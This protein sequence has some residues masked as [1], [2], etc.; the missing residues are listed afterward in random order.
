MAS[1]T[2]RP[3]PE[4]LPRPKAHTPLARARLLRP[5]ASCSCRLSGSLMLPPFLPGLTTWPIGRAG[6]LRFPGCSPISSATCT[7]W[8]TLISSS[9]TRPTKE[10]ARRMLRRSGVEVDAADASITFHRIPT[11]R[12]W[13]RDTGPIFVREIAN[14]GVQ[15]FRRSG[16]L[17]GADFKRVADVKVLGANSRS[18]TPQTLSLRTQNS[19]LLLALDWRFNAWAKYPD[20][21]RDDTV[22]S[23]LA[24]TL[25][26]ATLPPTYEPESVEQ[27][28]TLADTKPRSRSA[29]SPEP[30]RVVLEGAA[31]TSTARASC[32][33]TEEC[34]LDP[35]VQMRNPGF[36]RADYERVFR[37]YLGIEKTIWLRNGVAG[38]DTHGHVDDLARFVARD[39][40]VIVS[41][42]DPRDANHEPL[43][44]NLA[45]LGRPA[46]CA[47]SLCASSLSPCPRPSSLKASVF[48]QATPISTSPTRLSS[49]R[50]S[51][52]P[53]IGSP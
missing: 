26:Y 33:T 18:P 1:P 48:R 9:M 28:P 49:F 45:M 14:E 43:K 23:R 27:T 50:P 20:W 42:P 25:G 7:A 2:R 12:I 19:S 52:I 44:E 6:L 22:P 17:Q 29:R 31:L 24:A 15:A 41:E 10:R 53:T 32:S 34:L 30:R 4:Q 5:S 35:V 39:T 51:T 11:N 47:A 36:S 16:V 37:D 21:E 40:I 38:D 46:T 3:G 13:T 8:N